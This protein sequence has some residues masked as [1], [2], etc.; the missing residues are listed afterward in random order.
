MVHVFAPTD[1]P[2][3]EAAYRQIHGIWNRCRD[4]LG[5]VDEVP[6][7]GLPTGLPPGA[8][9]LTPGRP[10]AAIQDRAADYQAVVRREHDV[11]N[12][13][14][15]FAA[16][17]DT[18]SRRL[19]IG[20]ASP[21]GW[22][23]FDRWW[24]ELATGGTDALFGI[25]RVCQAKFGDRSI[26]SLD[27]IAHD[28]RAVLPGAD[29]VPYWWQRG[30]TTG[31]GLAVWEVSPDD[32]QAE[33]RVVVIA[34]G[35]QD[36]ELSA[37]TWSQ[38]D[39]AMPPLA[40]YLMHAAKLRYQARV[41]GD[42][43]QLKR[44]IDRVNDHVA[45][46]RTALERG[47]TAYAALARLRLDEADLASALR[48][49]RT[50]RRTVE[51]AVDN[52]T[53]ALAEPFGS[54]RRLA[55]WLASQLS[56]DAEY[57]EATR[58]VARE[59]GRLA[60][61]GPTDAERAQPELPAPPDA[62][63]TRRPES[64]STAHRGAPDRISLRMGFAVDIERYSSRTSPEKASLQ[65]RLAAL[66]RE[67]LDDMGYRLDETDH[68]DTGD[69]MNVFLPVEVELHRALPRLLLSWQAHL[70]ADNARFR[71]RMRLRMATAF[72]PVGLAA[73]GFAGSTIV[74]VSRLLNSAVLR[75][76]LAD[77][78]DTDLAVLVSEQL[79]AY[80]IGEGYPGLDA[81]QF[82]RRAV[83]VKEFRQHA[84]LWV[85]E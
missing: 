83:E 45:Q 27:V 29:H 48:D 7:T 16:P 46:V 26:P 56:D 4:G 9:M 82:E 67:V 65:E 47:S 5:M 62:D 6:S 76:A 42:G 84:W 43:E 58:E 50:M 51:I 32:G 41:R 25:V 17:L 52:M 49:V 33:R 66:V 77:H 53:T 59:F 55:E 8:N 71:D 69:G 61:Q 74:E 10:V 15:V 78:P 18:R 70:V 3:A 63:R 72:G 80:V 31:D 79:Y 23:E 57:L 2:Y 85:P 28:V 54:D 39:P 21:P 73:L 12:L 11:V 34:P 75:G 24:N 22:V 40:R 64:P 81:R 68:Q 19:R 60:Q 1:G 38:G 14:M 30:W 37:W 20:S 44:L 35:D 13:S 36:A